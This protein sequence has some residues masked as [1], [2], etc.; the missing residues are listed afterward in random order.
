MWS[1]VR[2]GVGGHALTEASPSTPP[3]ML[4]LPA[5]PP[6]TTTTVD[7]GQSHEHVHDTTFIR[8]RRDDDLRCAVW[9]IVVKEWVGGKSFILFFEQN[10]V[11]VF[12]HRVACFGVVIAESTTINLVGVGWDRTGQT[13]L[14]SPR[15]GMARRPSA[16]LRRF[17]Y[18]GSEDSQE[19]YSGAS[20]A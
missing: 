1:R 13:L 5:S 17:Y 11:S 15:A 19:P 2:W 16:S 12:R 14:P 3:L 10:F 20:W 8:R 18:H 7:E 6:T 9:L 4:T